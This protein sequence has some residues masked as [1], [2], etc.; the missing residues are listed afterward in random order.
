M[1]YGILFV[2][3]SGEKIS[4]LAGWILHTTYFT[5][6]AIW[7]EFKVE[8]TTIAEATLRSRTEVKMESAQSNGKRRLHTIER[9]DSRREKPPI[10]SIWG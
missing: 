5:I 1:R 2:G 6:P 10:I 3:N 9:K 7:D 8:P 4:A